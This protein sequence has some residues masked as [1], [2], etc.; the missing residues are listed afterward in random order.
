MSVRNVPAIGG[1]PV[2]VVTPLTVW[3]VYYCTVY[4]GGDAVMGGHG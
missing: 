1:G 3:V 2:P 4:S